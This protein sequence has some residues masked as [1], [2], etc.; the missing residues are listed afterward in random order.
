M[1]ASEVLRRYA[2][3]KRDFRGANLRGQSFEGQDLSGADFSEADIRSA[4]FNNANL[5]EAKFCGA[6]AGLQR[7]WAT[8]LVLVSLLLAVFPG[9]IAAG[10]SF[11]IKLFL[12]IPIINKYASF[13]V[14]KTWLF[15]TKNLEIL[16]IIIITIIS[17]II[18]SIII[19]FLTALNDGLSTRFYSLRSFS[20]KMS[21][22]KNEQ[23]LYLDT[24]TGSVATIVAGVLAVFFAGSFTFA[25]ATAGSIAFIFTVF[26]ATVVAVVITLAEV[27]TVF[28][29]ISI[30]MFRIYQL[31]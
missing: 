20:M 17:T 30:F 9:L 24:R 3:G 26:V 10:I 16:I 27:G 1:K 12:G 11:G 7:R 4:N 15:L 31:D 6:K 14:H 29:F 5:R 25:I 21:S 28:I 13:F 22:D 18:F 2:E 19:E 23:D 8:I